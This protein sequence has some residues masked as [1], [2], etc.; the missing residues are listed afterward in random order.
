MQE[1]VLPD[2]YYKGMELEIIWLKRDVELLQDRIRFLEG[3]L[4]RVAEAK[5]GP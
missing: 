5:K 2:S 4:S 3:E 1:S